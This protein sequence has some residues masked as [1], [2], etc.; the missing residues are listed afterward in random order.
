[1]EEESYVYVTFAGLNMNSLMAR[2]FDENMQQASDLCLISESPIDFSKLPK[3]MAGFEELLGLINNGERRS[4]YQDLLPSE[5]IFNERK[6]QW[7]SNPLAQSNL[8]RLRNAELQLITWNSS[9]SLI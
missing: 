3:N 4:I 8:D 2:Y 5:L 9:F 7:L 1:M 6:S